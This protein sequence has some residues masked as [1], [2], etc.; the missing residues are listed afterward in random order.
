VKDFSTLLNSLAVLAWP[1]IALVAFVLLLPVLRQRLKA[2]DVE[3][4]IGAADIKLTNPVLN[5]LPTLEAGRERGNGK[6]TLRY[7]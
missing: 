6:L 2:A 1:V 3:V 7:R 5:W 4:K